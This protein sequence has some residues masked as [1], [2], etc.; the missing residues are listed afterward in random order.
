MDNDSRRIDS[1][2]LGAVMSVDAG[3]RGT[4]Y[5]DAFES[6]REGY[7]GIGHVAADFMGS[8]TGGPAP[9]HGQLHQPDRRRP[10]HVELRVGLRGRRQQHGSQPRATPT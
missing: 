2:Q 3:T 8:P 5:F 4:Y 9:L 6:R 10:G 1:V 7:I